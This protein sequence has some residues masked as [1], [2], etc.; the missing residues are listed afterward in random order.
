MRFLVH[1]FSHFFRTGGRYLEILTSKRY[2]L[3][4]SLNAFTTDIYENTYVYIMDVLT[5]VFLIMT[6]GL[7]LMIFFVPK[8]R[9][10]GELRLLTLLSG[11]CAVCCIITDPE[12]N[13]STIGLLPIFPV[14]FIMLHT[15]IS[16][17]GRR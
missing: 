2:I 11:I 10:V 14:V 6:I 9:Y 1:A 13:T 17:A 12:L 16:L 8:E 4:Y 3:R 15:I 7:Y 5:I